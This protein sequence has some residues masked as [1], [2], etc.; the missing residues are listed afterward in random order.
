MMKVS[1]ISFHRKR[2]C[3]SVVSIYVIVF[4]FAAAGGAAEETKGGQASPQGTVLTIAEG[5]AIATTESRVMKIAGENINISR[6]E[7]D[8][9]MSILLPS[10][11]AE[12]SEG[13][14]SNK[15]TAIFGSM[16]VPM[17]NRDS[18]SYGVNLKQTLFNFGANTSSY[19]ASLEALEATKVDYE[20]IRNL[21]A[22][23]LILG[24]YEVL[25]YDKFIE[26]SQMEIERLDVHLKVA[27]ELFKEGV[28]TKNDLLQA[29]VRLSDAKQRLL[30]VKNLRMVSASKLNNILMRPPMAELRIAEP[31]EEER[32]MAEVGQFLEMAESQRPE[33]RIIDHELQALT[34][35]R[36]VKMSEFLPAFYAQGGYNYTQNDYQVYEGNW[37]VMLGAKLNIFSGGATKAELSKLRYKKEKLAE[38]RKKLIDDIKL[39][40]ARYYLIGNS[41]VE[42]LLVMKDS[43][44]QAEE[45]LRINRTRYE[46]GQGTAIDVIDAITLLTKIQTNYYSALYERKRAYA[47]LLYSSGA[48]LKEQFK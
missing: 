46:Q 39:E 34:L 19:K 27:L 13:F 17:A 44:A 1:T 25:E 33:I 14:L 40:I 30:S 21:T 32:P 43:V 8:V 23:E 18:F 3:R 15:P 16:Q 11:N 37:S 9:A 38:E 6:K 35:Q 2:L 10:I 12:V 31:A 28:I 24:C 4:L 45:N 5:L 41:A 47:G 22:L 42:K 48:D 36:K 20:R 7:T 26:V 29:E